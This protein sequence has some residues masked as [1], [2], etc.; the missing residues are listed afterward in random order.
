M[1]K[2]RKDAMDMT[3]SGIAIGIGSSV[4]GSVGSTEGQKALGNVA[5]FLPM[6][7]TLS[8]AGM[9]LR[10]LKKIKR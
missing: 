2:Y 3:K 8:G 7:G 6:M 5:G 9:T 1:R 4:L 10:Q